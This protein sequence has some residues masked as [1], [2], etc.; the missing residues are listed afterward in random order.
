MSR[1]SYHRLKFSLYFLY[2]FIL[3]FVLGTRYW[4]TFVRI[5][6]APSLTQT[7]TLRRK[8]SFYD[9]FEYRTIKTCQNEKSNILL[10]IAI[11]SSYERLLIYLPAMVETWMLTTTIEIE[12][13][14]FIEEKSIGTEEFIQ[15]LFFQ[16]NKHP[17]IKSCLFIVKL[18]YVQN[19]YPP[20]KK[21]FYAMK[22]IY[23]YYRQ[24][25]SW[26]LRLD[27]NA[28]VNIEELTKWLIS[29]DHRRALYIG[30]SGSGRQNGPAIYFPPGKVIKKNFV[31]FYI[32]LIFSTFVWVVVE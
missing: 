5:R 7:T 24:R 16:L 3:G 26:L 10:T 25:T 6:C 9:H 27:D 31:S 4:Q 32:D 12:I 19:E 2:F 18:K 20:Q 14:I 15:K 1:I 13:I 29:I 17:T 11:L 30:Q 8:D 21:S 28:Y 22:F 23:T